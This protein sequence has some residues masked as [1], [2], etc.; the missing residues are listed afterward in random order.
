MCSLSFV[1]DTK[2]KINV[3]YGELLEDGHVKRFIGNRDFSFDYTAKPGENN[4]TNYMLRLACRYIEIESEFPIDIECVGIIPQTYPVRENKVFLTDELDKKIYDIC[5]NTLKLCMMEHYVDCPWRE[6]CLYAFDSRNQMLA[7]YIAFEGGNFD[8]VRGNL[9]LMSKDTK[10]D[11]VLSICYPC[12][13]A[14]TIPSFSLYYILA[15]KEYLD[16]SGDLSLGHE[17]FAKLTGIIKSF[18]DNS[19]DG[20]LC[21]FSGEHRWNFYDWSEYAQG[22]IYSNEPAEPDFLINAIGVIALRAYGDICT[23]LSKSNVYEGL[24]DSIAAKAADKY[25][26]NEKGTFFILDRTESATELANSL[27]VLSGIADESVTKDICAK[28]AS[29]MLLPC[30]LSMKTFKYDAMLKCDKEKYSKTV[31]DEIRT[32]YK[33]MLDAG[34]T[35]VWETAEGAVAFDNAGS[36]CHGWSAIPIYYYDLLMN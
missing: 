12:G 30:S 32:A 22:H 23:K 17:V 31:L 8:Y 29:G 27:A 9:L 19:Q 1:S 33:L 4:Y 14:L 6:Q 21:K 26:D 25:Y 28:L 24:A 35:T 16:Y 5:V 10:P 2:Q 34:S 36:L 20:L 15:V 3:S 11:N 13:K 7:G 18:A